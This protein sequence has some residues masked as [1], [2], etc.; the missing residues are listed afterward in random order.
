MIAQK[1]YGC[2][3]GLAPHVSTDYRAAKRVKREDSLFN[4]LVWHLT[5][6]APDFR[7]GR[8]VPLAGSR[9]Y[10]RVRFLIQK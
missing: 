4:I 5:S 9:A 10:D 1:A 6:P 7:V 8:G 2:R 3:A